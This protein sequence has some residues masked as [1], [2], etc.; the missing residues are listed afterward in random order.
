MGQTS[1]S[2]AEQRIHTGRSGVGLALVRQSTAL[3][4]L[5]TGGGQFTLGRTHHGT[6]GEHLTG[7][8]REAACGLDDLG[9]GVPMRTIRF[10]S[11]TPSPVTV[12]MRLVTGL[13]SYTAR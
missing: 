7:V 8:L 3:V 5:S 2:W 4:P 13:P 10:G 1:L 11:F 9:A 12:T 6:T